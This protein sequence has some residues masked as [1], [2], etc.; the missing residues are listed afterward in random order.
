MKT[1]EKVLFEK[2]YESPIAYGYKKE[3]K[4]KTQIEVIMYFDFKE[5]LRF[6]VKSGNVSNC[7]KNIFKAFIRTL[8]HESIGMAKYDQMKYDARKCGIYNRLDIK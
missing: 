7:S 3:H 5:G 8:E 2:D 4:V 6:S 1:I